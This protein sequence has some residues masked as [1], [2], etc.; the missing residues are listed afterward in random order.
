[1]SGCNK[2]N[3][4]KKKKNEAWNIFGSKAK[5]DKPELIKLKNGIFV[6]K[7]NSPS[8]NPPDYSGKD[9]FNNLETNFGPSSINFNAEKPK[10][11]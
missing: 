10:Y 5:S 6:Y 7:D 3:S 4:I 11:Q 1:M 8:E 2:D 9:P